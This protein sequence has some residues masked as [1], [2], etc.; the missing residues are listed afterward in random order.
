MANPV[1]KLRAELK[2]VS[3]QF[4]NPFAYPCLVAK[5]DVCERFMEENRDNS[6]WLSYG[7]GSVRH[8]TNGIRFDLIKSEWMDGSNFYGAPLFYGWSL[9]QIEDRF[10]AD[11]PDSI[12][13]KVAVAY[14]HY[15][16]HEEFVEQN[17]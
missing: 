9:K 16:D 11:D 13:E 12:P 5:L 3:E 8:I 14:L 10:I 2:Q 4:E 1:I 6:V 17:N 15:Q 7:R